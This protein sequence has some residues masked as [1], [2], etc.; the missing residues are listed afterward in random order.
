MS[1]ALEV[2]AVARAL[3]G[4]VT[5]GDSVLCPGPGHSRHDRSLSVRLDPSVP[6][7]FVRF[8]HSGD[9]WKDCRDYVRQCLGLP[10]WRAADVKKSGVKPTHAPTSH[11]T[12]GISDLSEDEWRRASQLVL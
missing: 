10:S 4:D 7:G 3:G 2:M 9:N 6:D 5:G 12:P 1:A 8:S 11:E